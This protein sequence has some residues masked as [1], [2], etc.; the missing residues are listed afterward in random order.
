MI[1]QTGELGETVAAIVSGETT[2]SIDQGGASEEPQ[3]IRYRIL[4]PVVSCSMF[5]AVMLTIGCVYFATR[6]F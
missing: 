5:I 3:I 4:R 1:P 2:M 6:D